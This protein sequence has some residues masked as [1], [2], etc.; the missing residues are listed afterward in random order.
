MRQVVI[1]CWPWFCS[2]CICIRKKT[3]VCRIPSYFYSWIFFPLT[4]PKYRYQNKLTSGVMY[5]LVS[6][7]FFKWCLSF[8]TNNIALS[9]VFF[10]LYKSFYWGMLRVFHFHITFFRLIQAF[11]LCMQ[12]FTYSRNGSC[13][14]GSW[15]WIRMKVISI[16][17]FFMGKYFLQVF[18]TSRPIFWVWYSLW[19]W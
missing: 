4:F 19:G 10:F 9:F 12:S 5:S 16:F 15:E 18:W 1:I 13:S 8:N 2:Q 17:P 11:Q 3:L 14:L 7:V 6:D